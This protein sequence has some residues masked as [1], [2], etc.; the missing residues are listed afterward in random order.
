MGDY[1]FHSHAFEK[2]YFNRSP[3]RTNREIRG[4]SLSKASVPGHGHTMLL[5]EA[6]NVISHRHPNRNNHWRGIDS[7]RF[8]RPRTCPTAPSQGLS[9]KARKWRTGIPTQI[10]VAL[11]PEVF[12]PSMPQ[13][14]PP[15]KGSL[16]LHA[17]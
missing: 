7:E 2:N 9:S 11:K 16:H 3:V 12:P 1:S 15:I 10:R 5:R 13:S 6:G 17:V 14:S 8:M 4:P